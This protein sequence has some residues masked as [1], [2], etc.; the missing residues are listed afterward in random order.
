MFITRPRDIRYMVVYGYAR[1]VGYDETFTLRPDILKDVDVE[2]GRIFTLHLRKGHKWSDGEPFTAED[3][4]YWWEDVA[5]NP[6]LA[7]G[8]PPE[9]MLVDGRKPVFEVIDETTVRYTW[10]APN[11]RFL[12]ALAAARPP[13][14]YRPA[15][16]M[17]QFHVKYADPEKLKKRIRRRKA[18]SWASLHNGY[19]NMYKFDNPSLP[20]LQPWM[21]MSKKN[22]SRYVL[23]RNPFYHRVDP[24]GRQL[25][26]IDQVELTVAAGGLIPAKVSRG[27]S[28]LQVRGLSFSDAPVLKKGEKDGGYR[29]LLWTS[30]AGSEMALY[31]NQTVNDPEWRRL[32]RDRR[33]RF[34]L[35]HGLSRKTINKILF[36]GVARPAAV[37]ALPQSPF[38]KRISSLTPDTTP[39]SPTAC[40]TKSAS[41]SATARAGGCC[42]TGGAPNSSSRPPANGWKS[43]TR[44]S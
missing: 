8:G 32:M 9:L 29:T 14:I 16:Y 10:P 11:P 3:F 42:P 27:E 36:F 28:D 24:E 6:E 15:H 35:S 39:N 2:E 19:D 43:W 22:N 44:W 18:R 17:K 20:T 25:P 4:R 5:N 38:Y 1:L 34:A 31:P 33:F 23:Q 13:F 30:G 37:A 7:P 26:Y 40:W 21:N 12:P 41:T